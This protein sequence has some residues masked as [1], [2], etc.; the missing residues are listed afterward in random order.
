MIRGLFV[1]LLFQFLGELV[2]IATGTVLPG[3]VI[4][5]LLLL[6][7]LLLRGGVPEW[8]GKTASAL[9][10]QLALLLMPPSVGL[11]FLGDQLHG[12]WPA[13]AGAV[14]LGTFLTLLFSAAVMQYLMRAARKDRAP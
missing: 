5:L 6:V 2:K 14:V 3:A 11:Y 4:G 1:L 13:I 9:I 12:Q 10:G 8:L 7:A